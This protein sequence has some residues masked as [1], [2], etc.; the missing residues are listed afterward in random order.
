MRPVSITA[1]AI[2]AN[3]QPAPADSGRWTWALDCART[4][5]RLYQATDCFTN[6][7][8]AIGAAKRFLNLD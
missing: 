3:G 5:E 4:E 8:A 7:A 1:L 2:T 6:P